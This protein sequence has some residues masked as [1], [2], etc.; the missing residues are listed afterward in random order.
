VTIEQRS[1]RWYFAAPPM[2]RSGPLSAD[3]RAMVRDALGVRDEEILDCAWVDNGPG[4]MGVLLPSADRVLAL[5]AETIAGKLGVVGAYPPGSPFAYELRGFYSS[6]GVT[7]EDPVTG[8]VNASAAQWLIGG[9][10]F[11]APYVVQQG[12][13]LGRAGRVHI[14]TDANDAVWVGGDV[15]TC[16]H[17]TI[18]C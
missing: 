12:T 6:G 15:V 2:R 17:G 1:S 7:F 11:T 16:I 18:D 5:K 4:W 3:E 14:D 10:Y 8:S 13:A 9:G